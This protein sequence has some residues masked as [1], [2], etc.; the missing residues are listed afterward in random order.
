VDDALRARA[1][2]YLE[3]H[4]VMT[5]AT[6]GPDGP[7]AAAVF[8][9]SDG[10]RLYFLSSPR[11][12]HAQHLAAHPRAGAAIHEDYRDWPEIKGIQLEGRVAELSGPELDAARARYAAKFPVVG[13]A[14]RLP[15]V[16]AAALARVRWYVLVPDALHLVDN[17]AGFGKRERVI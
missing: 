9:A 15:P 14:A 17:A 8:Y 5:L 6:A 12:R 4:Q 11:S 2:D 1:L 7:W 13:N 16:L 10:F 3:R